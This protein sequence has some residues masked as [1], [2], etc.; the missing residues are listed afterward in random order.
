MAQAPQNREAATDCGGGTWA[1]PRRH[2]LTWS[3]AI[4]AVFSLGFASL[5]FALGVLIALCA[6]ADA[7]RMRHPE[8]HAA[9]LR[10]A[11]P[12][13]ALKGFAVPGW[14]EQQTRDWLDSY[15]GGTD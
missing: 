11:Q 1:L 5:D 2:W 15:H 12:V 6:A 10:P 13:A 8:P 9:H 7:A 14:T 4:R 3:D